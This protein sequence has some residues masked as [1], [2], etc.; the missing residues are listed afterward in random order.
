M[1]CDLIFNPCTVFNCLCSSNYTLTCY[2]T[3]TYLHSVLLYLTCILYSRLCDLNSLSSDL[4]ADLSDL[5]IQHCSGNN[6]VIQMSAAL[7]L[8]VWL[9]KHPD[10][11]SS[12]LDRLMTTYS[13]KRTT[14]PPKKDSFGRNIFIEYKDPWEC[15]VG[16]AKALEQLSKHADSAEAMELLKFVIPEALSD[17]SPK[18]QSA[19]MAAAKAA[20]SCHGDQLAGELMAHSE[21]CLKA[22]PDSQEA[23]VVRQSIIVLMGTLARHMDKENPKV[24]VSM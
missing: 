20:I 22:I 5:L 6:L 14:P 10:Q 24:G 4:T 19:V 12:T 15:R 2:L 1:Y 13:A 23:D 17:P 3:C 8:G 18:V 21:E 16:V 9:E 7:A 11:L